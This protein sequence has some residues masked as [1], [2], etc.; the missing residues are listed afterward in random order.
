MHTSQ[1]NVACKA[2][3]KK[4]EVTLANDSPRRALEEVEVEE[5]MD[6][7]KAVTVE[8]NGVRRLLLDVLVPGVA[9]DRWGTW[10]TGSFKIS[11]LG[12]TQ[13]SAKGTTIAV[14]LPT[15]G[16]C[17]TLKAFVGKDKKCL[18]AALSPPGH[19]VCPVQQ[20][21]LP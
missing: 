3:V 8:R 16:A 11:N 12:L 18:T 10:S 15:T 21:V 5:G 14:L 9:T 20:F 2:G 4:S 1:D 17:S 7:P 19:R 13:A 6:V